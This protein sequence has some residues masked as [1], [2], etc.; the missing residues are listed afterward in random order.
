MSTR[1]NRLA[2][3]TSPY[4]LQHATNPVDWYPW[5]EE[6]LQRA[7]REDK[8]ILLSIGYAACHWC[9]VMERESFEDE[10]TAALMNEHF[11]CIKVDR[12]ERPDIDDIYMN[13]TIAISG[14]GGWPMTV[15]LTPA[16]EPFFAGTYFP[17]ENKYGRPGFPTL[18]RRVA[19]AWR[20]ERDDITAQAKQLTAAIREGSKTPASAPLPEDAAAR[21][22]ADLA[23]AYD[24]RF[25]GFGHAPK[26]PPTPALG[27]LIDTQARTPDP[28]VLRMIHGTLQ[29]MQRGG[30]YDHI[31]GGFCRYSTDERWLVPHFEKM[32]YDNAQ[33][34]RV[35][36]AAY[37][38]TGE[39]SY[40]RTAREILDYICKEMQHAEGGYYSATDADS[41]GEEGKFF[42]WTPEE[43]EAAT[44]EA[45]LPPELATWLCRYY[46]ITEEGNFEG[47][48][49]PNTPRPLEEVVASLGVSGVGFGEALQRGVEALYAAREARVHPLLDDKILVSWN[50]LML[51]SMAEGYRV[52]RDARYLESATRAARFLLTRLTR[53]DG[54]LLRTA[55]FTESGF[56]AHLAGYLEDYAYLTDGLIDLVEA[57]G[58]PS[59]LRDAERLAERMLADFGAEEGALF[60][61]ARD[62]EALIVRTR[63]G[64]DGAL[65]APNAIAARALIRLADHL[66]REDLRAQATRAIEAYAS[67]IAR[68]PRAFASTLRAAARLTSPAVELCIAGASEASEA[69]ERAVARVYLPN[70]VIAYAR[71]GDSDPPLPL[72]EG[73]PPERAALYVCQGFACQAPVSDPDQVVGALRQALE[74]SSGA[75]QATTS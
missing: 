3:E 61:T 68:V 1:K 44:L 4:L 48:S 9:H 42:V 75:T 73:K 14:S 7:V 55:R 23:Q 13:A 21:A 40:A 20:D 5:G 52:L 35:Y 58:P 39:A 24:A 72:A 56:H 54:G 2:G 30:M 11:V 62:H 33:L 22:I 70:Q 50:G 65:P 67:Q 63:E 27:L 6:A 38:L 36:L 31:G 60:H 51:G 69:L 59:L 15:M 34:S 46:D 17:P 66:Q 74:A 25:G 49:I 37:Q 43:V 8:P 12:E 47:K 53:P 45:E 18:L 19:E 10:A 64:H 71:P 26:F 57:G 41:E 28:G 32:L 29:G 16:Q